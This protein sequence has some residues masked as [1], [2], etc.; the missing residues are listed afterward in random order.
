MSA[1]Q[2]HQ[3]RTLDR[4]TFRPFLRTR[5][6]P[7]TSIYSV[8]VARIA[9]LELDTQFERVLTRVDVVSPRR[10][11]K[12]LHHLPRSSAPTR[13]LDSD[14]SGRLIGG[15]NQVISRDG[16]VEDVWEDYLRVLT[17]GLREK[18]LMHDL[19]KRL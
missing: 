10:I 8:L 15:A 17:T 18:R 5:P 7:Q 13:S 16:S 4:I 2:Q 1:S 9:G 12:P 6:H 14:E 3:S 19:H 11:E